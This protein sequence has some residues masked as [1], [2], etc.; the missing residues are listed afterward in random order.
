MFSES[1]FF[2]NSEYILRFSPPTYVKFVAWYWHNH[3]ARYIV[4]S[5]DRKWLITSD[6]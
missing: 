6:K 1:V 3:S 2:Q 4:L 5:T